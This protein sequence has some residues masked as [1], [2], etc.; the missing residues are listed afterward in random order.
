M[1][2][3][4]VKAILSAVDRGFS[5]TMRGA[6]GM[7]GKLENKINH[8]A[9]GLIMGAGMQAFSMLT[10]GAVELVGEINAASKAW[11][12]FEGNMRNFGKSEKEIGRV[13]KALQGYAETTV[14]SSSDMAST[15]A[16]ME[17]V[18]VGSMKALEGGTLGLVKGF[19]GLAAAAEDPAQA[20]KALS[21]QATQMAAKPTVAWEDFKIM[22]EQTPAGMAAVAKE[23]NMTTDELIA[24]IQAGEIATDEF[25]AAVE[26]AGNSDGFQNMATQAKTVDQAFAGLKETAAN[27]LLPA[28]QLL[29][30]KGI[31][32]IDGITAK[33]SELDGDKIAEKVSGWIEKA[34]PY[35][36]Q[37][38]K[39]LIIVGNI[40]KKVGKFLLEHSNIISK[41][42]P[43]I[44]MAVAAYKGFK[45][46]ST[47]VGAV[48]TF[49]N[50]IL[51]LAG[52]AG[53]K[54][55]ENLD[56]TSAAQEKVGKTSMEANKNMLASAKAF[57][58]L[59]AGVL[60]VAAGFALLAISAIKLAE[61]G[62]LAIGVMFGLVVA[63]AAVGAGMGFLLKTLAPMGAQMVP[64]GLAML[65]MGAAVL[66]VA[67][68]FLLL[69]NASIKLANAGGAAIACMV[70]MVV[71]V[72]ALAVGAAVL[73]PAMTAGA[74]GLI[75]FGIAAAL[76]GAGV[77]M[78]STGLARLGS[79][80]PII[81]A[82][83]FQASAAIVALGASMIVFAA[84]AIIAGA[85]A[86][87]LGA[88]LLIATIG[89]A[90]FGAAML[91]ASAGMLIMAGALKLVNSSMKSIAKNA[92]TTQK[93]LKSMRSSV[94]VV[95]SG[96]DALGNKAKSAMNKL[97]S[98]F[99]NTA[100]KAKSA[101]KKVGTGFAN[102][103]KSGLT[104]AVNNAKSVGGK[105]IT[106]VRSAYPGMYSAG[107][108]IANG[109]ALGMKS[110]LGVI[111]KI[112]DQ[113][114]REAER[115]VRAK[116]QIHSPSKLFAKLGAYI[117]EGFANGIAGMQRTVANVSDNLVSIPSAATPSLAMAYSGELS[118]AYSYGGGAF[119]FEIPFNID[120][121][122][123][124][125]ATA[126]YTQDELDKKQA[127]NSRTRG[128]V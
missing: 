109:L 15:Y 100:N 1:A 67:A 8:F 121:R 34:T 29:S 126:S 60:M 66:L 51:G 3:F 33:L 70:G 45:I 14:Y 95:G 87:V 97:K 128:K 46:V 25:F 89:V 28:F 63:L 75:A 82:Y 88:G 78:A 57:M 12:T 69:A 118:D 31:V 101:G 108:Y 19:G 43:I 80:L 65:A 58:M 86:I 112:A 124:A 24:K 120:G 37:F 68:G 35:W 16:Q 72:A 4:S 13:T 107:A 62:P 7:T 123:F 61:A 9:S 11:K 17:A 55:A 77:L 40:I 22:L 56:K 5:S 39:I 26:R 36:E 114:A 83:G 74:V 32:A 59:G 53:S 94:K 21:Q 47:V 84:G 103:M 127:R 6:I 125:K 122:E 81:A 115:A 23:M 27:K 48:K 49:S 99:D 79:Q 91:L 110:Q 96:L 18:G 90:A 119:E 44:L 104:S 106:A 102:G 92:K 117:G 64:V 71:A 85:G 105:V 50:S 42:I 76:V 54:V 30:D 113:M 10:N 2:D 93:S 116:A 20:M 73:G 52:K 41:A 38:K 98:A 111:K